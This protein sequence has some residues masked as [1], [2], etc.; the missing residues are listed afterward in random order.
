MNRMFTALV[1]ALMFVGVA[2]SEDTTSASIVGVW[3]QTAQDSTDMSTSASRLFVKIDENG[4]YSTTSPNS[5]SASQKYKYTLE[6]DKL[7]IDL[8]NGVTQ[9]YKVLVLNANEL[10][11]KFVSGF[12]NEYTF[13]RSSDQSA[14]QVGVTF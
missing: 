9:E 4:N 13:K 14:T 10:K 1:A 2:C 7:M 11:I 6:G 3:E 12:G 8:Q 5:F